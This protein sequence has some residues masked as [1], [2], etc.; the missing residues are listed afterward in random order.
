[1]EVCETKKRLPVT[2]TINKEIETEDSRF[3]DITIDVLHTGLNANGSIFSKAVVDENADSIKNTPILGY[4]AENTHGEDDFTKHEYKEIGSGSDKKYVYNGNAYGVIPE[5]CNY[6]WIEKVS[7]D[8]IRREYFQV[9]GLLWTKFDEAVFIFKRDG[10]KPQSMELELASIE[11]KELDDGTFEFSKFRFDGCCLLSSTDETIEPAMIDSVA[12]PTF[13]VDTITQEIKNKLAEYS[14]IINYKGGSSVTEKEK[15]SLTLNDKV[16]EI[17][18]LLEEHTFIS[19]CG[20]ECGQYY[21][22]DVQE[23][24]V[25]VVNRKDHYRLYGIPFTEENDKIVISFNEAKRVKTQ[26]VDIEDA[27]S[28]GDN[29]SL[30]ENIFSTLEEKIVKAE[31]DCAEIKKTYDE[32]R[33]KYDNYVEEEK[34]RKQKEE[35]LAKTKEFEKFDKH[36]SQN[37]KYTALKEHQNE[38][39]LEDIQK[40]CAILFTE[41]NLNT[42]FNKKTKDKVMTAKIADTVSH[43]EI[44]PRYG[45]METK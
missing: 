6:R 35:T 23:N 34:S 18:A 43:V 2:F 24:K 10:G 11:G 13:T 42:D 8:G 21:F 5:S 45:V 29:L 36:L 22:V 27:E 30:E 38:Y 33:P 7:S 28:T 9:N 1:M 26:Y 25:I 37:E 14:Q 4:I 3:L 32:M 17:I 39:T 41:M 16:D 40:E 44:N 15:F 20:Y 31:K 12:V 19:P